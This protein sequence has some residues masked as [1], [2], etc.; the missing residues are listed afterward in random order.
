MII[1]P[2]AK[3]TKGFWDER[4]ARASQLQE[5]AEVPYSP[6][7]ATL[8]DLFSMKWL[9]QHPESATQIYEVYRVQ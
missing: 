1:G 3:R 9:R 5:I 6:G 2:H 7:T 4:L 8:L